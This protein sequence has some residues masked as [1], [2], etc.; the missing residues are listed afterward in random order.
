M[1]I[2]RKFNVHDTVIQMAW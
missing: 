2:N 1:S